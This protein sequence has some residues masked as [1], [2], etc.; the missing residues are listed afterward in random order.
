M[1][2]FVPNGYLIQDLNKPTNYIQTFKYF[3]INSYNHFPLST[4]NNKKCQE[5]TDLQSIKTDTDGCNQFLEFISNNNLYEDYIN[6]CF[7]NG[8]SIRVL[9]CEST[10]KNEVFSD[11]LPEMKFLGYEYCPIP[12]DEQIITD[13]DCFEL[14]K[15]HKSKLNKFGLFNTFD[16]VLLFKKAYDEFVVNEIIGDGLECSYIFKVYEVN[17]KSKKL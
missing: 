7:E 1:F 9:F 13:L 6:C 17:V 10:Y 5:L 11:S 4:I 12:L 15:I 14:F 16:D 3:G 8:I 2:Q